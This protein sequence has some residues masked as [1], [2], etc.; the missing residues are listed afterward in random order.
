MKKRQVAAAKRLEQQLNGQWKPAAH[1]AKKAEAE[2]SV[3]P[4]ETKLTEHT[5][6]K[7]KNAQGKKKATKSSSSKRKPQNGPL[8]KAMREFMA[9][10][11]QNGLK[12]QQALHQWKFSEERK[13]I[14]S[15][16]SMSERARRRY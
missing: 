6:K 10:C 16:V 15:T 11:K 9:R 13:A 5:S 1:E 3:C 7:A 4:K 12:Y 8:T 14:V 2:D